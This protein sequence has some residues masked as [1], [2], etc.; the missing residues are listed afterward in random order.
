LVKPILQN[1]QDREYVEKRE[2]RFFASELGMVV[3]ELLVQSFP[4]IL[5]VQFTSEMEDKLDLVEEGKVDWVKM[6][7]GFWTPFQ[8]TLEQAKIR[9]KDVKS[10][11]VP[12]D[13]KCEKCSAH[14]VIKWGKLGQFLACSNYPE[15]KQTCDF[16][17]DEAGKIVPL[18]KE[19]SGKI[20]KTCGAEMLVKSGKFGKFLA[21]EKYPD[22]KQTEAITMGISCPL[23]KEGEITQR[24][25]RYKRFFYGCNRYPNCTFAT[26]DKPV[27]E[28]CPDCSFPILTEKLTKRDGHYLKCPQKTC[29]YRK[30]L[31]APGAAPAVAQAT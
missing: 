20:C 17:K 24:M 11:E 7:G 14:M 21:C 31:E 15:C 29:G 1:L 23:C 5:N 8:T 9:M 18:P 6:M 30:M 10:M 26:W 3:T 4:D 22:C 13:V 12:T 19:K 28:T 16:K 25:S 2:N 27:K